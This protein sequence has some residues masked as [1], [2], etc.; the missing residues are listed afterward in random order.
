MKIN[1]AKYF[2]KY[3]LRNSEDYIFLV[4]NAWDSA[5]HNVVLNLKTLERQSRDFGNLPVAGAVKA[6]YG[7]AT[8]QIQRNTTETWRQFGNIMYSTSPF[9]F[10]MLL[11]FWTPERNLAHSARHTTIIDH[12]RK[13]RSLSA[14]GDKLYFRSCHCWRVRSVR[15]VLWHVIFNSWE[16][17]PPVFQK[18]SLLPPCMSP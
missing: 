2:P 18:F 7:T 10:F 17:F 1:K 12:E 6:F 15:V 14:V 5:V 4:T 9:I 8:R 13:R 3:I 16:S 11:V